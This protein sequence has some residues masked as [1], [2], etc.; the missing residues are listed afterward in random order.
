MGAFLFPSISIAAYRAE[1]LCM[2]PWGD[3]ADS[4]PAYPP[5]TVEA[6]MP[7][8]TTLKPGTG[9][10]M[11]VGGP[12]HVFIDNSENIYIT[13][14][15]MTLTPSPDNYQLRVFD[16][17]GK[18]SARFEKN[19]FIMDTIVVQ[20]NRAFFVDSQMNIFFFHANHRFGKYD[21]LYEVST[22]G[23]NLR[24]IRIPISDTKIRGYC[25]NSAD[26]FML[27]GADNNYYTLKNNNILEG[28]RCGWFSLNGYYYDIKFVDS[29]NIE[30]LRYQ[31]PDQKGK[32]D[33]IIAGYLTFDRPKKGAE[34]LG[35]DDNLNIYVESCEGDSLIAK[36][37]YV[38]IVDSTF[39]HIDNFEL[40]LV[41]PN[42]Y[43]YTIGNPIFFKSTGIVYE[44]RLLD[45]GLHVIKWTKQ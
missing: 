12:S 27:R 45:D 19:K 38:D 21:G 28:G 24:E 11:P 14:D 7:A 43:E 25:Q 6:D 39:N 13:S 8:D 29:V 4:F 16:R 17:N 3:G 31:N 35:L 33:S 37:R 42:K 5:D 15:L 40:F 36:H 22:S 2:I 9:F 20:M 10:L 23:E 1:E 18:E 30:Y 32:A 41:K 44:M 26:M 34:L